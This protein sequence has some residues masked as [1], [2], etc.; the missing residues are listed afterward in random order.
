MDDLISATVRSV[1][2]S[3]ILKNALVI[4]V[5]LAWLGWGCMAMKWKARLY[6]RMKQECDLERLNEP[7]ENDTKMEGNT[8]FCYPEPEGEGPLTKMCPT[9]GE[10][11]AENR[12][13]CMYQSCNWDTLV[14]RPITEPLQ[15]TVSLTTTNDTVAKL[16]ILLNEIDEA[17]TKPSE[18]EQ[19]IDEAEKLLEAELRKTRDELED[20]AYEYGNKRHGYTFSDQE[21]LSI[22]NLYNEVRKQSHEGEKAS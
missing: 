13:H 15:L 19:E 3:Y 20:K 2:L 9:C 4:G 22:Y 21:T 8:T 6:A 14:H 11:Y 1:F 5:V 16:N 12:Q 17:S 10:R 18:I 7:K